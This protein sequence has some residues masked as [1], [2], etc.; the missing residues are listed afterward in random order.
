MFMWKNSVIL[1]L[2]LCYVNLPL[3]LSFTAL[4]KYPYVGVLI[5]FCS[6]VFSWDTIVAY[7]ISTNKSGARLTR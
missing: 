7:N 5:Y 3:G 1:M 6:C 4:G 2:V